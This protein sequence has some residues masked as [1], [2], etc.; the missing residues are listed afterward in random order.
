MLLKNQELTPPLLS[1]PLHI[2]KT[3]RFDGSCRCCREQEG[4]QDQGSDE[5]EE[6]Y[7]PELDR[8]NDENGKDAKD[9]L[10]RA[11]KF[12]VIRKGV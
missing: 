9:E 2:T 3:Y 6:P 5:P 4:H 12:D 8:D 7:P 11:T 1:Q 10:E